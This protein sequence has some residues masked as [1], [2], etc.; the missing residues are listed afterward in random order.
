MWV[1]GTY[2]QLA[3]RY[4]E[5][6]LTGACLPPV[7]TEEERVGEEQVVSGDWRKVEGRGGGRVSASWV[8]ELSLWPL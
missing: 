4:L 3:L 7:V 1:S 2:I 8:C 5:P 6:L